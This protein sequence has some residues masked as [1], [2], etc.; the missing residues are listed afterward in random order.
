MEDDFLN[1]AQARCTL[2]LNASTTPPPAPSKHVTWIAELGHAFNPN[3]F[4]KHRLNSATFQTKMDIFCNINGG[5]HK[6][7][8]TL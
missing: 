8:F 5:L 1:S 3:L 2:A 6:L 4:Q 7:Q